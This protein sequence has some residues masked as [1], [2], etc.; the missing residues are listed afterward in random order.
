M[1]SAHRLAGAGIVQSVQCL[2]TDCTAGVRS[3]TE[4]KDFSPNLCVQTGSGA[5][6]ASYTVGTGGSF[7][8]GKAR[9]GRDADH[10]P[11]SSAGVRKEQELYLL[12]PKAPP[13]RVTG[14]KEITCSGPSHGFKKLLP[15]Y[16]LPCLLAFFAKHGNSRTARYFAFPLVN[17]SA[18]NSDFYSNKVTFKL[19]N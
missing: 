14:P 9:P 7:T 3:P 11:P 19:T 10:S 15:T 6:P 5:H 4:A 16:S 17:S 1:C 12:S 13:W 18:V 8:G 2:T